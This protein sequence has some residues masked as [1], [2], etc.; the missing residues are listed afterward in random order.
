MNK[1]PIIG[2]VGFGIIN[3]ALA[4][5]FGN[6]ADFRIYDVK[7]EICQNSLEE[8]CKDSEFIFIGVPTP[9]HI[10]TGVFDKSIL[11]GVLEK[12]HP[13]VKHSATADDKIVVIRST[14]VPGTTEEY[15]KKYS[16]MNIVY[17]PE[18]LREASYLLDFINPSRI[19]LGGKK[20]LTEKVEE[21]YRLKFQSTPI[22]H[23]TPTTA[24]MV[25]YTSN[26]FLATKVVFFNEIYQICQK[27]GISYK[28]VSKLVIADGRIGNSHYEV[29]GSDGLFCIGGKCFIKDLNALIARAKELGI[30]PKVMD[31][32]WKKTLEMRQKKDWLQI[33]GVVSKASP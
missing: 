10:E 5:G 27:L 13:L 25:K 6:L 22:Y 18:F 19:I 8:V 30:D 23:T 1:K 7:P 14:I 16:D 24:E 9:M 28:E 11:D 2:L 26:C 29:P 3:R 4:Y 21:L 12:I 15:I 31:S 17:N 33:E 20:E 32:V